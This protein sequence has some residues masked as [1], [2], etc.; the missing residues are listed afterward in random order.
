MKADPEGE[1]M[2]SARTKKEDENDVTRRELEI[3]ER[4]ASRVAKPPC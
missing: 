3:S 4:K 1:R 2:E